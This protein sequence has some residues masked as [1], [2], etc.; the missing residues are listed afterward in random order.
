MR[1]KYDLMLSGQTLALD[2]E[3][4]PQQLSGVAL[5]LWPESIQKCR[6]LKEDMFPSGNTG[7]NQL[8]VSSISKK[9]L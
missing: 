4:F 3:Y 8:V 5:C 2:L 1:K 6:H 9:S 7:G